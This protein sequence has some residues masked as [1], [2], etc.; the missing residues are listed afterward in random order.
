[1]THGID[2]DKPSHFDWDPGDPP[3]SP[4]TFSFTHEPCPPR[5]PLYLR[6]FALFPMSHGFA[7]D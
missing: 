6:F 2:P 7:H 5:K 1:M 3:A 4:Q